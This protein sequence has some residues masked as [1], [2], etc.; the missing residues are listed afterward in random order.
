MIRFRIIFL[1]MVVLTLLIMLA[2]IF[3]GFASGLFTYHGTCYGFTDGSW[4]CSWQEYA[5]DQ[6]FWSALLDIPLSMYIIPCWLVALGFWLYKRRSANPNELPLSMVILIPLVGC[7]GG[8][9][10]ISIFPIFI[11]L[12]YGFYP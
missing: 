11:R 3:L 10:L 12:Y 1:V 5:S 6:V 8:G 4:A 9:C 2:P 7:L